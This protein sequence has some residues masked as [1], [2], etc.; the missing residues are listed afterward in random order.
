MTDDARQLQQLLKIGMARAGRPP[1]GLG[2]PLDALLPADAAATPEAALWL[3][4]GALDV[5]ERSGFV[6]PDQPAPRPVPVAAPETLRPCPPRAQAVL[7]QLLRGLHPAGLEAEWLRLLHRHGGHVPAHVLPKLLDA[8]T[9]QPA[10][11]APL[12]PVLGERGRWLARLQPEWSWAGDDTDAASW[13]T[14]TPEQRVAA[15]RSWRARAP[16]AARAALAAAWPSEPPDQRAALLATLSTALGPD[17]ETFLEAAL[18]DR[19]KEVRTVAQRLLARLPTSQLAQRMTG[20]LLPLLRLERPLLRA[21]RI[22]LTL[23]ETLDAAMRRDGIGAASH[24]GLG[25]KAGWVVDMLAA[26]DPDVWT[27]HFDRPPRGCL[28]LAEH[29][30]FATVFARGWALAVQRHAQDDPSPHQQAWLRDFTAW[31]LAVP[32]QRE[33]VP[34]SLFDVAAAHFGHDAD[35]A[36]S[37]LFDALPGKW[38]ADGACVRLLAQ[39]AAGAPDTWPAALSR[40]AMQ[41]LYPVLPALADT[42]HPWLVRQ[43]L[44][45]L[46]LVLD[47]ATAAAFDR[48]RLPDAQWQSAVDAFFDL[49]HLRHEMTLSFQETA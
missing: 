21:A 48:V 39:L 10:L 19:R 9:R 25:E 22:D 26:V 17:D 35:G 45:S 46:A 44:S 4:L 31:W 28:A 24:P 41:R 5:W 43:L 29:S 42:G 37:A 6:A 30:E 1:A 18:D 47:P 32:A 15:L 13:D 40:H 12:L 3:S 16:Q 49:V 34:D 36:S 38:I 7:A 14:G 8:G 23:P 27:R 20:R 2:A 11:R 33:A